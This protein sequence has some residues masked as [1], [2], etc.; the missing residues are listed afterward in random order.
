MPFYKRDGEEVL[1]APN[2]VEGPGYTLTEETRDEY[3]Y[4]VDGWYWFSDLDAALNGIPRESDGNVVTMRQAR[5]AL[6][7]AGLLDDVEAAVA[8]LDE[9]ARIEWE[10]ASTV[11][12]NSALVQSLS[13]VLGITDTQLDALFANA[14]TL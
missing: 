7:D 4:P 5:L 11:D 1:L 3:T 6:F 12:R 2:G 14:A 8:T 13:N 9:T 10:Y